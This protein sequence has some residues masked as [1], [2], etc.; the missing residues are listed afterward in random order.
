MSKIVIAAGALA[1]LAIAAPAMAE[2][3]PAAAGATT[4]SDDKDPNRVV[5][6]RMEVTGSRLASK[7]VCQTAAQWDAMEAA[8][9]QD[10]E[11]SQTQR[12]KSD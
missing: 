1:L 9:R 4:K 5:C 10:I 8:Q 2:P 12:W 3:A 7:R 6:R 11:R